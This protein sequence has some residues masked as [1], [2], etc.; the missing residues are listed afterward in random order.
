MKYLFSAFCLLVSIVSFSQESEYISEA[1]RSNNVMYFSILRQSELSIHYERILRL[2]N[3]RLSINPHVG[4]GYITGSAEK[5][6]PAAV[7]LYHGLYGLA[8]IGKF[9][10]EAGAD[11]VV[12]DF[13]G[14]FYSSVNGNFGVRYQPLVKES[15]ML[16]LTYNPMFYTSNPHND[17]NAPYGFSVGIGF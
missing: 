11:F 8:G 17:F 1:S 13:G 16:S 10:V 15:V 7:N 2:K 9:H 6:V 3:E 4:S 14:V 5:D 12:Q